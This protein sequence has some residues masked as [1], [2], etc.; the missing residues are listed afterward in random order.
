KKL[1]ELRK[2]FDKE[3]NSQR[4]DLNDLETKTILD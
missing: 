2:M 4:R 1:A 3:F